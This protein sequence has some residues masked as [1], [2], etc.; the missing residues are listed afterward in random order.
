[1]TNLEGQFTLNFDLKTLEELRAARV[2][3]VV[4]V[5]ETA[6]ALGIAAA[7]LAGGMNVI[8][9]TL[10]TDAALAAIRALKERHPDLCVGAGTVSSGDDLAKAASAG[11]DFVVTPG[12]TPVLL[13]ALVES[14]VP[15][16][17]GAQTSSEIMALYEAGF[18]VV[19]FF[20]AEACGGVDAIKALGGP[21]RDVRFVPTGGIG[22]SQVRGYLDLPN[23]LAVGGSWV[24]PSKLIEAGDWGQIESNARRVGEL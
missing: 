15:V 12:V 9:I 7:L 14:P 22:P 21:L 13:D 6:Q 18:E 10:R 3:P 1:M 11:V 17:P 19:K 23:V 8:E 20:P 2:I 4:T 5:N 16:I 24:A